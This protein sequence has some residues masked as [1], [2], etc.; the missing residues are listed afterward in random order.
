[1]ATLRPHQTYGFYNTD[2]TLGRFGWAPGAPFFLHRFQDTVFLCFL[3]FFVILGAQRV[4]QRG[5][6]F[7]RKMSK[8]RF[9]RQI[10]PRR[11]RSPKRV[12]K[13][14]QN[15]TKS[16]PNLMIL[17]PK[18]HWSQNPEFKQYVC[19]NKS[20]ALRPVLW[21]FFDMVLVAEYSHPEAKNLSVHL[22]HSQL[23]QARWRLV[24][25][26]IGYIYI[27]IYIYIWVLSYIVGPGCY[28][29]YW[30]SRN[31]SWNL[32]EPSGLQVLF[33]LLTEATYGLAF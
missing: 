10:A 3:W 19:K 15:V 1:M 30:P 13:S 32:P 2:H 23:L 6:T 18:S 12:A 25:Q 16:D 11:S 14:R 28:R 31:P 7:A 8:N 5:E 20:R 17:V 4:P 33:T 26:R 9:R 29:N 27:Y 24:A 21:M 22:E